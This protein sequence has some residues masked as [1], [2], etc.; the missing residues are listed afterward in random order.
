M[1]MF[2]I[3]LSCT[4]AEQCMQSFKKTCDQADQSELISSEECNYWVFEQGYKA[5]MQALLNKSN[6][7]TSSH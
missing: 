3:N 6:H 5:A 2:D 4:E 1:I 7:V